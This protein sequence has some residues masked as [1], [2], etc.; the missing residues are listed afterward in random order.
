MNYGEVA[1]NLPPPS[2]TAQLLQSTSISKVRLYSANPNLIQALAGTNI[3][4]VIGTSNADIPKLASDPSFASQWVSSNV[5]PFVPR[6]AISVI[7]VGNELLNSGDTSLYPQLLPAMQNLQAAV[8]PNSGIKVSTVHSMAVMSASDPPSSGA[9]HSDLS[10][11]I[12][13]I[14]QFLSENGGPFMIN[15]YPYFAYRDDPRPETLAY[16]L[17]QPNPG[18]MDPNTKITYMNMFDAQVKCTSQVE[19]WQ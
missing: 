12:N 4:I 14:L 11:F 10:P 5:A 6:S 3:S 17:F 13:P 16:C 15:P 8:P 2:V 7:S 1:N 9:F 18:R 19:S